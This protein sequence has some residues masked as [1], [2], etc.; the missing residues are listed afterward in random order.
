MFTL[1][2][3]FSFLMTDCKDFADFH[4]RSSFHKWIQWNKCSDCK[5]DY[6]PA[7]A[8][9]SGTSSRRSAPSRKMALLARN[10]CRALS[11]VIDVSPLLRPE[12]QCV[13][14]RNVREV[15]KLA[16]IMNNATAPSTWRGKRSQG[17]RM[18][19]CLYIVIFLSKTHPRVG[20]ACC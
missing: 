12:S 1:I 6:S 19:R 4:V 16:T 20:K 10:I 14:L 2:N 9:A 18:F 11:Q 3:V 8:S 5:R 7:I 17:H 15:R 13:H